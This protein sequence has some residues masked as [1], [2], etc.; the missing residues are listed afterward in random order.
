[1]TRSEL[2][3]ALNLR[4]QALLALRGATA[5]A[6]AGAALSCLLL[7]FILSFQGPGDGQ[8]SPRDAVVM[9]STGTLLAAT[10]FLA[11]LGMKL[12]SKLLEAAWNDHFA[13]ST[14]KTPAGEVG[15]FVASD[16]LGGRL[17]LEFDQ[18]GVDDFGADDL[19]SL[20]GIDMTSISSWSLAGVASLFALLPVFGLGL[21]VHSIQAGTEA[22]L[23]GGA[24]AALGLG[25][26]VAGISF[27]FF[28]R[29][30]GSARN[31][32][33]H[34]LSVCEWK[35]LDGRIG[36]VRHVRPGFE[37][38]DDRL[39]VVFPDGSRV[40]TDKRDLIPVVAETAKPGIEIAA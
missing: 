25:A 10:A 19:K 20:D 22:V 35:T 5:G 12:L 17:S 4:T 36:K 39:T 13:G 40:R 14:W 24:C 29:P 37:D 8:F 26:I 6:S 2:Q 27:F 15:S 16:D 3:T 33:L 28:P 30:Y 7:V 11:G 9:L 1:M 31:E 34:Q 18:G 32:R 38:V 23:H 21:I